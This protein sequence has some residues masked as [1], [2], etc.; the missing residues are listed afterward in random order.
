MM[1]QLQKEILI[2]LKKLV[3]DGPKDH[4]FGICS[5]VTKHLDD[6][7][8]A[9]SEVAAERELEAAFDT[10]PDKSNNKKYPV[11]NWTLSPNKLFW[12][13]C[14]DGRSMWDPNTRYG[15]ARLRLLQH[16][17]THFLKLGNQE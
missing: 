9:Y 4:A 17:L 8:F 6:V 1:N 7:L 15:K 11:G 14:N 10:W 2:A 3:V 13:H 5:E 16:T 12:K